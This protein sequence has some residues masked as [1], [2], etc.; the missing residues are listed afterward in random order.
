MDPYAEE[1]KESR[2][3]GML[4]HLAGLLGCVIPFMGGVLGPLAVWLL[5]KDEFPNVD[6]QGREALNFQISVA[7][8][9]AIAFALIFF[10]I[11]VPLLVL[12]EAFQIAFTIVAAVK[13]SD[14]I[15][16]RYPLTIRFL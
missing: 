14:G 10:V 3:W 8:Y 7:I 5:K 1:S 6:R 13:A 2:L 15:Y 9:E 4:A 12:V 11:G 16:Y